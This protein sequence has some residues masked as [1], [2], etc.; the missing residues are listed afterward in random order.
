MG[1]CI[2]VQSEPNVGT[3][4]T[5]KVKI[6]D[7]TFNENMRSVHEGFSYPSEDFI[8][9]EIMNKK[10]YPISQRTKLMSSLKNSYDTLPM[11]A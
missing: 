3:K 10:N 11:M 4:F 1:G 9:L 8:S 5:F 2:E 7:S 6:N